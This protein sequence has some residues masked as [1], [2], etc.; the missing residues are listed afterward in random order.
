MI[1][2]FDNEYQI[3][4]HYA[5]DFGGH[6]DRGMGAGDWDRN[7]GHW[8]DQPKTWSLV[9]KMLRGKYDASKDE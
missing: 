4:S 7:A 3:V 6:Y 9:F 5:G 8:R 1:G 2:R